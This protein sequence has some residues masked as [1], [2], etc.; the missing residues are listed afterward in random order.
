MLIHA[1]AGQE[2]LNHRP[3][4]IACLS[5]YFSGKKKSSWTLFIQQIF[6]EH[7]LSPDTVLG[8]GDGVGAVVWVTSGRVATYFGGTVD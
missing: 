3:I 5:V 8:A 1:L 6:T 4:K 7:L 2:I